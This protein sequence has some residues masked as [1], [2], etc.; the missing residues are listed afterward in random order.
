MQSWSEHYGIEKYY[1]DVE[2]LLADENIDAVHN[3]TPNSLHLKI[4]REV[5]KSGKHLLSE[6]PF[7]M[8][9]EEARELVE[10]KKAHPGQV[11]AVNFNYRMNPMVQEMRHSM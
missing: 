3:C 5:L 6:K 2:E 4:N 8:N 10:L 9:Y 11:A 7:C 1:T